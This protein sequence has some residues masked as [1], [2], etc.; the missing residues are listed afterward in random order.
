MS[1]Y[2]MSLVLFA[3]S[4]ALSFMP[5][6]VRV[7]PT[8]AAAADAPKAR[9]AVR[10][11][12]PKESWAAQG[13]YWEGDPLASEGWLENVEVD[14][15]VETPVPETPAAAFD[16]DIEEAVEE[17]KAFVPAASGRG[18]GAGVRVGAGAGGRGR[19][20]EGQEGHEAVPKNPLADFEWKPE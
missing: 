14:V 8:A 16:V 13:D 2:P 4:P 15:V 19:A 10:C 12:V 9:T 18:R 11:M 1:R 3:A 17:V 6:C 20:A 7:N 5:T